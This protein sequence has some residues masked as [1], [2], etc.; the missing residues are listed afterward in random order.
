MQEKT[1]L[2]SV[3]AKEAGRVCRATIKYG[4]P[5]YA[6]YEGLKKLGVIGGDSKSEDLVA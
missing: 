2:L 3:L 1:K 6:G 4:L 5:S